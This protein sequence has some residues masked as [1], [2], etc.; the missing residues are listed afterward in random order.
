MGPL[1]FA[2]FII[3]LIFGLIRWRAGGIVGLIL[4][5][6]LFD[7][8]GVEIQTPF[9]LESLDQIRQIALANPIAILVGDALLLALVIYLWKIHPAGRGRKHS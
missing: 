7:L 2:P 1:I 5:H 4:V 6:G 9:T 3:G 8:V